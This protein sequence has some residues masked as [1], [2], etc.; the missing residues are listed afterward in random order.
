TVRIQR[1]IAIRIE[2]ESLQAFVP[3]ARLPLADISMPEVKDFPIEVPDLASHGFIKGFGPGDISVL[4]ALV[5][6]VAFHQFIEAMVGGTDHRAIPSADDACVIEAV[7]VQNLAARRPC[8]TIRASAFPAFKKMPDAC[9]RRQAG[10]DGE[11]ARRPRLLHLSSAIF[12]R[13]PTRRKIMRMFEH[14]DDRE[15][16]QHPGG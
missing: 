8:K 14:L 9:C 7:P 11:S 2:L 13:Y 1:D 5:H 4:L 10:C 15:P 6:V 3:S 16:I 12:C